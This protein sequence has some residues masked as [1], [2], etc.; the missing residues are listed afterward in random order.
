MNSD[1]ASENDPDNHCDGDG[2]TNIGIPAPRPPLDDT[3]ETSREIG[4]TD[5]VWW[6]DQPRKRGHDRR[7]W[8]QVERIS[9]P[10]GDRLRDNLAAAIRDLLDWARQQ[11]DNAENDSREDG[12]ADDT[13]A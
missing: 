8:G 4:S 10:E 13:P 3:I 7:Y 12:G 5:S 6:Y 2:P 9:G 1:R 11:A